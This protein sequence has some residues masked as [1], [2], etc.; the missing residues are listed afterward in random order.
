[1][2]RPWAP[3]MG[4]Q[5]RPRVFAHSTLQNILSALLKLHEKHGCLFHFHWPT[6]ENLS[7]LAVLYVTLSASSSIMYVQQ[8]L[9][10]CSG[11]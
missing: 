6:W 8:F 7:F 4:L 1:M 9:K 10:V 11:S 5:L 3:Y 2:T